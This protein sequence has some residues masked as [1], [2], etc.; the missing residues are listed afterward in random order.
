M[1]PVYRVTSTA[2][3]NFQRLFIDHQQYNGIGNSVNWS[4]QSTLSFATT[5]A[6]LVVISSARQSVPTYSQVGV[7]LSLPLF[8]LPPRPNFPTFETIFPPLQL[9]CPGM[10]RDVSPPSKIKDILKK[11]L[12]P[13]PNFALGET[14]PLFPNRVKWIPHLSARQCHYFG[15]ILGIFF[16]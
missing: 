8:A 13:P 4:A 6:R 1:T 14:L 9:V 12:P 2:E 3:F 7:A 5:P 15:K 10:S 16:N 11:K